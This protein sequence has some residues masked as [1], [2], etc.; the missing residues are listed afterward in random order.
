MNM[1]TPIPSALTLWELIQD[2]PHY[3]ITRATF[4]LD[5]DNKNRPRAGIFVRQWPKSPL[6]F[7][8]LMIRLRDVKIPM[9]TIQ[10]IL[11]R[12]HS[13]IRSVGVVLHPIDQI[14]TTAPLHTNR[15]SVWLA[16]PD[17]LGIRTYRRAGF[18]GS[19]PLENY[20]WLNHFP[21]M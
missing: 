1:L 8:K 9:T 15:L 4:A 14:I 21:T 11:W 10:M 18:E 20:I 12:L 16:Y 19:L 3:R 7:H 13:A 5:P 17:I 6:I 2:F